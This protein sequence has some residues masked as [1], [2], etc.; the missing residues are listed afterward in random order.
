MSYNVCGKAFSIPD[1]EARGVEPCESGIEFPPLVQPD[2][3]KC[4]LY[5]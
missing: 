1:L 2:E 5:Y 3:I 4:K